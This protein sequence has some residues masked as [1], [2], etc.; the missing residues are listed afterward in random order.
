MAYEVSTHHL[1]IVRMSACRIRGIYIVQQIYCRRRFRLLQLSSSG[2]R[3]M[4]LKKS[5]FVFISLWDPGG[6]NRS[7][8]TARCN[9]VI[10]SLCNSTNSPSRLTSNKFSAT[11]IFALTQISSGNYSMLV[12]RRDIVATHTSP[13]NVKSIYIPR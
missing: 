2:S 7:W 5:I 4:V 13:G 12:F 8:F 11:G 10:L 6:K 9:S 3:T 1:M